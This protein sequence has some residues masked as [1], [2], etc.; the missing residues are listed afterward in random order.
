MKP[1]PKACIIGAGPSGLTTAKALKARGIPFDCFE[2]SDD[3]GGVWYYK[4]P[5]GMSAAYR[6]LHINT[7]KD[8]MAFSDFPMAGEWPNFCHHSLVFTYFRAYAEHFG[9]REHITFQTPVRRAERDADG[10]WAITLG[11]GETRYYDALFV[12]NGHHWDPHWPEPPFP[13]HFEGRTLH[14]HDYKGDEDFRGQRVVVVGMGNSG[15]DI[16]V[17]LSYQA[18]KTLLSMRRGS[19]IV[20]KYILGRPL[21]A[22][23][24]PWAPVSMTKL[25]LR[26][27]LH[28]AVGPVTQY[29]IP[30][31][32]HGPL[33]SHPAISSAIL[34][35]LAHRDIHPKPNVAGFEGKQV[36]FVDGTVEDVDVVIYATGYKVSFPFFDP[37]FLSAKD[38]DLP[39]YLRMIRPEIPN[40][41]FIGLYQPLGAIFPLAEQQAILAAE[42]LAGR[43]ALPDAATME[44]QI[45]RERAAMFKRYYQSKRHT[46]QVDFHPFMRQLQR[47]QR[48]GAKRARTLQTL[49]VPALAE[50][51]VASCAS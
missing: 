12:C 51:R 50:S 42:Y 36:R 22:W 21:D 7:S 33:S 16:A 40:L 32:D 1:L 15:L 37:G 29:G 34:D 24:L 47:A 41:F 48:V 46:M 27:M 3:V 9:L 45:A 30:K 18:E 43:C 14:S 10:V 17:E 39:L 26:V 13:G 2:A 23:V 28:L 19:Y 20:P 44:R 25:M 38:N 31:P 11:N 35:R 8:R 6:G 5:T 49:P 4:N